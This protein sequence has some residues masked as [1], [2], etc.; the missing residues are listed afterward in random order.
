MASFVARRAALGLRS[1]HV[2]CTRRAIHLTP[3]VQKKKAAAVEIEDLF[4]DAVEE[5]LIPSQTVKTTPTASTS[6]TTKTSK[7]IK[8]TTSSRK[9]S[10]EMRLARFDKIL[11]FI[12]HRLG[13]EPQVNVNVPCGSW[14]QLVQLATTEQQL[15]ALVEALPSWKLAGLKDAKVKLPDGF[16]E[17]FARRCEELNCPLLSLKVY[18]D[19]ARYNVP[20]PLPAARQLIHSLH[21]K[22]PLENVMTAAA[23]YDVYNLPAASEDVVSASMIA[24]A[25]FKHNTHHSLAVANAIVPQIQANIKQKKPR[26]LQPRKEGA[27]PVTFDQKPDI[28]LKWAL[29]KVDKAIF[30]KTGT[31]ANWLKSWRE[32]SGHLEARGK[33]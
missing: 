20:L 24:A 33:F 23:L 6:K 26:A 4:S 10:P 8:S 13:Q 16:S 30:V 2:V 9:L 11:A 7:Q 3:I 1:S 14:S 5:D 15:E 29:K 21:T 28:W 25:C 22:Y 19:F 18:G 32:R 31:R 17:L 27:P 12:K